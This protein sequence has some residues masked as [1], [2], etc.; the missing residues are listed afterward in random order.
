MKRFLLIAIML[1]IGV[2]LKAQ[3][4]LTEAVDFTVTDI[5]GTEVHLFDILDSGQAVLIDFFFTTCGP[6][7]A[8]C[9]KLVQAYTALGCNMYD[10][11]FIEVDKGDSDAAC[12]NWANTYGVEY[13]T[14]SGVGGGTAIC[15]QYHINAFPTVILIMPDH[16]IAIQDLYP[17]PSAQAVISQLGNHGIEQHDCNDFVGELTITPDTLWF[18]NMGEEQTFT[19]SNGTADPVTIEDIVPEED[20]YLNI[21]DNNFPYTLEADQS[22]D[23][24][25]TFL[26]PP[27]KNEHTSFIITVSTSLGDR[28]VVA[29]VSN[30]A[31]D[32]GLMI[33]GSPYLELD[34][35]N[36]MLELSV[37]NG[38]Y[39]TQ[40]PI[41]INSVEEVAEGDPYLNIELTNELP[42][43]LNA[44]DIFYFI[45]SPLQT[46]E[47]SQANT[48]VNV[49]YEGGTVS[50]FIAIDGELLNITELNNTLAIYPN[51]A[52]E[53]L[54]LKGENL[55]RVRIYNALGQKMDEVEAEGNELHINTTGYK[56]GMYF[57][58]INE[59][60]L[61]FVVSH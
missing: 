1:M 27:A 3:T 26:M 16:S 56:N 32:L 54:L 33:P 34:T 49:N 5:H 7:Q 37:V 21:F 47:R 52:N 51:P 20:S 44:G 45:I 24:T 4:N 9:P 53:S 50:F 39:G 55:G 59:Q 29:M 38:N 17:I 11:Y 43:T 14:I 22:L 41:V 15:N 42:F 57:V 35:L 60:M 28:E 18:S 31:L 46:G 13:P 36:S 25:V 10:V 8:S 58:K 48:I 61:K 23:V 2:G 30:P 6:C 19:I 40:E 12:I